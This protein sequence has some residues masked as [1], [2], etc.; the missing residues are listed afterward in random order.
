LNIPEEL[1]P[2]PENPELQI[3][4]FRHGETTWTQSGQHTS[5]SDIRLTEEGK[6]QAA[7]M[8]TRLQ[9]ISFEA[10]IS[11]PMHRAIET[12][13]LAGLGEHRKTD[14]DLMEW[15]YG[16]YEGLTSEQIWEIAPDWSVYANGV[17]DGESLHDITVRADRMIHKLRADKKNVANFSHG[18]FLRA[19]TA[20]WLK[21]PA[22]EGQLFSLRVASIGTLGFE[23]NENVLKLWDDTCHWS[24]HL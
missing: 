22:Q 15:N 23:H 8:K 19:L 13:E 17:S 9:K 11:S 5:V 24:E 10:V 21:L 4:L 14:E 20:R 12:C 2:P 16:S 18:H 6:R 1:I 7:A 3:F